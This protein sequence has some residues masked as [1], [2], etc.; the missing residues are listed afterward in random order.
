MQKL[1]ANPEKAARE[2]RKKKSSFS[3]FNPKR[4]NGE[5]NCLSYKLHICM[6]NRWNGYTLSLCK[7][8]SVQSLVSATSMRVSTVKCYVL[9]RQ[10]VELRYAPSTETWLKPEKQSFPYVSCLPQRVWTV[11]FRVTFLSHIWKAKKIN[12][13]AQQPETFYFESFSSCASLAHLIF[14]E[15]AFLLIEK[16]IYNSG[17]ELATFKKQSQTHLEVFKMNLL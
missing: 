9:E 17:L 7:H 3:A 12:T 6:G 8:F 13:V 10:A 5:K 1:N 14:P 4:E 11:Y 16:E 2:R 15:I